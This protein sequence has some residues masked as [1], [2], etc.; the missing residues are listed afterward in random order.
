M[1]KKA[2][3][4][5]TTTE[6]QK[7]AENIAHKMVEKRLAACAQISG[8]IISTYWWEGKVES[9]NE[10]KCTLKT[11]EEALEQLEKAI[12]DAHP[13]DVP[14]IIAVALDRVHKPYLDWLQKEL[15]C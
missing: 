13:Y 4:V 9:S 5:I 1:N 15:E 14:Q 10:W 11:S 3:M 12:V 2:Y 7:E 6:S 8:P